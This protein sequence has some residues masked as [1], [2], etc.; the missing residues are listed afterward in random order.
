MWTL[1]CSK[2]VTCSCL[3][4]VECS[5]YVTCSCLWTVEC[6]KYVTCS[7]L[8]AVECSKSTVIQNLKFKSL[9][10]NKFIFQ[11]LET[12]L[13]L[14]L[15]AFIV[16]IIQPSWIMLHSIVSYN[17]NV[18]LT[19]STGR[20]LFYSIMNI[21]ILWSITSNQWSSAPATVPCTTMHCCDGIL[22]CNIPV[23]QCT[24]RSALHYDAL[25]GRCVLW[26]YTS[27]TVNK[28]AVPC[29]GMLC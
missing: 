20:N 13:K 17:H 3:C 16:S 22:R 8:C 25:L 5:K 7:C 1:E 24:S 27:K 26:H 6:S 10:C 15:R 29:S 18:V 23:K 12:S 2:Y 4:A 14:V 21:I 9:H 28:Q 19:L 11:H